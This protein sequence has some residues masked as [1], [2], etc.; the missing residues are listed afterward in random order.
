MEIVLLS[1][2]GCNPCVRVRRLL[3]E[4]RADVPGLEVREVAM[5]SPEGFELALSYSVLFPPAVFLGRR[6]LAKGKVYPDPLREAI[7]REAA[8]RAS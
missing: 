2:A 4:I 6:L 8:K 1:Q 7:L 3:D 5:G